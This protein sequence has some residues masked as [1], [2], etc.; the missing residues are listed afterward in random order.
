MAKSAAFKTHLTNCATQKL[1]KGGPRLQLKPCV[2]NQNAM[3][4]YQSQMELI[5]ENI[6]REDEIHKSNPRNWLTTM[7]NIVG[8][9]TFQHAHADQG[10]YQ[11]YKEETTFPFVATHGF[12]FYP[13]QLWLLPASKGGKGKHGFLHTF[14]KTSMLFMR[15]DFVHAGGVLQ[16]PRCH[17]EFYPKPKAG[18]VHNHEHHYWLEEEF[19]S[20][21][22]NP[23]N[24]AQEEYIKASFLWQGLS[25]PFAYPSCKLVKNSRGHF[26]SVLTYPPDLTMDLLS[27]RKTPQRQMAWS[28]INCQRF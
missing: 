2:Q 25:F 6:F 22:N 18:L 26:R 3:L 15:G 12:G 11:E 19:A 4:A 1:V 14:S 13:F 5:L 27:Q 8:G 9:N 21:I 23:P 10:R 20:H 17:M 16:D 28:T 7:Q 24:V